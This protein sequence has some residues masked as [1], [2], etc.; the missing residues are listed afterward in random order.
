MDVR[1]A[2]DLAGF[3]RAA[4]DL[5]ARQVPPEAVTWSEDAAQV[6]LFGAATSASPCEAGAMPTPGPTVP[7]G[8]LRLCEAVI[9]HRDAQRFALLYRLLWRLAREPALR[10]DPLDPDLLQAAGM[11]RA[12]GRDIHKM[13]AFVRFRPV[14]DGKAGEGPLHVAWFEPQHHVVE[15]NAPWFQRRFANMR[16]AILTPDRC[17]EWDGQVLHLRAGARREDA[18]PADA[19]ESLWLTYYRSIFNPARLN[20]PQTVREMPRRYWSA[21]PEAQLISPLA[22]AARERTQRMIVQPATVPTRRVVPMAPRP[23]PRVATG[24]LDALAARLAACQA[25]PHAAHAT[26]VVPGHGPMRSALMLVGEQP[27]DAEDLRGLPFVGPAGQLLDRALLQAGIAREE[28]YLTNA[29]RH[30]KYELRGRRR[31]HKT[32]SQQD[33]L[34]CSPWLEEEI[35]LV[36]PGALVAL[37]ATAARTLLGRPV[38]VTSERGRWFTR[39]DGLRVL[40]RLHPS[41]LLRLPQAQRPAAFDAFVQDLRQAGGA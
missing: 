28:L 11:A 29:V 37:G 8:F 22:A 17:A 9:L 4:R 25:C 3:R 38:A 26:Q 36:R 32:P 13:R 39:D 2:S 34:A 35:A 14:D 27:G 41:A 40:V 6:D 24:T 20:L 31:L 10:H 1:H 15:A 5:L 23:A 12:V 21:L 7:A 19:G 18:P 30:F 33:A 16:W